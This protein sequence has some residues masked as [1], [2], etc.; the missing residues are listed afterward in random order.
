MSTTDYNRAAGRR[1]RHILDIVLVLALLALFTGCSDSPT[2]VDQAQVVGAEKELPPEFMFDRVYCQGTTC[3]HPG[4]ETIPGFADFD[5]N[6]IIEPAADG[7]SRFRVGFAAGYFIPT[8]HSIP[9]NWSW[10]AYRAPGVV[11][12]PHVDHGQLATP[13]RESNWILEFS[14]PVQTSTFQIGFDLYTEFYPGEV[15]W[16]TDAAEADW[17]MAVGKGL[18]PVHS[19]RN[20]NGGN[21]YAGPKDIVPRH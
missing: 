9:A 20:R 3:T 19:P 16:E 8:R 6:Y 21:I 10:R 13:V 2:G 11:G 5:Y 4:E 14:G 7:V 15:S 12:F 18:G 1:G 17:S